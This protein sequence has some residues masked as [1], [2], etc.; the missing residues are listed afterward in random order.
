MEKV[1]QICHEQNIANAFWCQS[2]Q[3]R[4]CKRGCHGTHGT[5][6][7]STT[8]CTQVNRASKAFEGTKHHQN[9]SCFL[10]VPSSS[11]L[12]NMRLVQLDWG[13]FHPEKEK[14]FVHFH[15]GVEPSPDSCICKADYTNARCHCSD[16]EYTPKWKRSRQANASG[17][18]A[19]CIHPY[20]VLIGYTTRLITPTLECIDNLEAALNVASTPDRLFLLCP[21]HYQE[22][23]ESF[24]KPPCASCGA[25]TKRSEYVTAQMLSLLQAGRHHPE[26]RLK[27]IFICTLTN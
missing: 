21:K 25:K 8:V 24:I 6:S 2:K 13:L 17:V 10:W 15:L 9:S 3:R 5:P 4:P 20:W 26:I 11:G 12:H 22:V 14:I 19:R 16:N 23:W 7:K 18:S 1:G 27:R